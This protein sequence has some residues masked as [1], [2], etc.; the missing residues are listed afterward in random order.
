LVPGAGLYD[1]G[2]WKTLDESDMSDRPAYQ[3]N[4]MSGNGT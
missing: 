4:L 2:T 3:V 1:S